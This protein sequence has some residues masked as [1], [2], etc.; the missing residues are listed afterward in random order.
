MFG[1]TWNFF[2]QIWEFL[3]D[4][5]GKI[6]P[7]CLCDLVRHQNSVNAIRWSPDGKILASADTDSAIFL[8]NYSES[9]AAPDIFGSEA[10]S[11]EVNEEN[12][13][14]LTTLRG[15]LQD[16]IGLSWSPDSQFLVSCST[17]NTAIV[18][19]AKKGTKLKMLDD[20]KGWV[21]GVTWDPLGKFIATISSDRI[22]R[23]Y[24]TKNYKILSK[25]SKSQMELE[26]NG[27][28]NVRLFHDDTFQSFFRRL[29]ISPDG[30]L[31]VVPSG[32]LE[33][34][35]ETSVKNCAYVFN[36][37]NLTS[38]VLYLPC[39]EI[40]IAVK[41]SPIKY[42]L[43]AVPRMDGIEAEEGKIWTKYQTLFALP[44]RMVFAV[45]T[46]NTIAFYDTQQA[47]PFARVSKIHYVSLNDLAW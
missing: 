41:F 5:S 34:D 23:F 13:T 14:V 39:K 3:R 44:Y 46:K 28:K 25:V 42:N 17:D 7:Q 16:V 26:E 32:V 18:F 33:I 35:G 10:K 38:P 43:R 2:F 40:S 11:D 27:A 47:E 12:W 21:N 6:Q 19:D 8:W 4:E 45:A 9:E 1:E 29:D 20:H 36:R 31:L 37:T 15:H 22:L 30:E 24:K